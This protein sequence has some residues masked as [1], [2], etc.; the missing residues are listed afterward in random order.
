MGKPRP[1]ETQISDVT[2]ASIT[3]DQVYWEG[4]REGVAENTLECD[5]I[6]NHVRT[7]LHIRFFSEPNFEDIGQAEEMSRD[8]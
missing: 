6:L 8:G 3:G 5:L 4:I 2:S 1:G 7:G